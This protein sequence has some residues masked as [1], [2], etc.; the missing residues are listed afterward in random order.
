[1]SWDLGRDIPDLE[2]LYARKLWADFWYP[3]KLALKIAHE[4][5]GLVRRDHPNSW[6]KTLREC[7]GKWKNPSCGFPSIPGIAPGV[8][9]RIVAF[10]L[11]K[12]WDAIPR[13]EFFIPRMIFLNSKSCSE[14]TPELSQRL[15]APRMAFSLRERFSWNWDGSQASDGAKQHLGIY[16]AQA[17]RRGWFSIV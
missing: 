6:K 8:A 10:A 14:N 15:R 12:S 9:P 17:F 4:R 2:K 5:W 7:R 3:I 11:L 16:L 1:M 13:M